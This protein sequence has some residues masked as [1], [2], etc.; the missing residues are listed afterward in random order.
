[1]KS[2]TIET[3]IYRTPWGYRAQV[4]VS[5]LPPAV[6]NFGPDTPLKD[7]REWR[8]TRRKELRAQ[9][10]KET[11]APPAAKSLAEGLAD[12]L[13]QKAAMPTL[14]QREEHMALWIAALGGANR[15]RD[16]VTSAEIRAILQGWRVAGSLKGKALSANTCNKRRTALMDYYTILN[17]RAGANPVRDVDKFTPDDALP[18]GRDPHVIDTA[19]KA[20]PLCRGRAC[21]R[22]LLWTGMRPCELAAAE[23]ED[24]DFPRNTLLIRTAKGGRTRLIDLTTQAVSAWKEFDRLDGWHAVPQTAPLNRSLKKWTGTTMR[25]YDLRHTYGTELVRKGVDIVVIAA[26]MGHST[27]DL[28]RRYTLAAVPARV[29]A[30]TKQLQTKS[31]KKAA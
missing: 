1:M 22:V 5:G 7:M 28:T 14:A 4:E 2:P 30:A 24:L 21:A 17:G 6:K 15:L 25:V 13:P 26:M 27:L 16:T 18:R 31:R 23:P 8:E 9:L 3:G 20:A 29:K 11:P 19:L 12:Y 10:K